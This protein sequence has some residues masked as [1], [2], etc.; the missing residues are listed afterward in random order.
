VIGG[1]DSIFF[2]NKTKKNYCLFLIITTILRT[3]SKEYFIK[4]F[5]A[6]SLKS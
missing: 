1:K 2:L 4:K 5:S 3:A 6:I